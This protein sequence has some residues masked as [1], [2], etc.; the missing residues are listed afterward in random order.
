MTGGR[1][2][3]IVEIEN[4]QEFQD[5]KEQLDAIKEMF[6]IALEVNFIRHSQKEKFDKIEELS[7]YMGDRKYKYREELYER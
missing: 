1:M 5:N 2:K 4:E 3:V 7:W 6:D